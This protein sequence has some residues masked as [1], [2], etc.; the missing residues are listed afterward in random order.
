MNI[1]VQ[2]QPEP[3]QQ[4][5]EQVLTNA[6]LVLPTE[7]L[8]GSVQIKQ[9]VITDVS[10][11]RSTL[12]R[13]L[14]LDGDWLLAGFIEMHTDNIEKQLQPRP[15]VIWPDSR[16]ALLVHDLQIAGAGI[17]TVYDALGL[18]EYSKASARRE[19]LSLSVA[20]ISDPDNRRHCRAEHFLHLRCELADAK[21][22]QFF[23]Q[24]ADNPHVRLMSLM[25]HTPGQR[26]WHDLE[27]YATFHRDKKWSPEDLA[28][29]VRQR[30][31]LQAE[32]SQVNRD[33]L[34]AQ[35]QARGLALASHDDTT[36]EHVQQAHDEGVV[37]SEFPTTVLAAELARSY[38]MATVMG[39]P[40]VVR[41]QSHSGNVSATELARLGLLDILSS[42]Y[43]PA[44]LVQAV[45]KLA[46]DAVL[47]LPEAAN[48]VTMN[49]AARLGLHD[50]GA[51][52]QGLRADL[53]RVTH[54]KQTPVVRQV[55]RQG[56]QVI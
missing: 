54:L 55:W 34:V 2:A 3:L 17:T 21:V 46:N 24:V 15:G 13:A 39:A 51:I 42:D 5:A 16:A 1:A 7:V 49:V 8:Y 37:I 30:Q 14:D 27:K 38:G 29:N 40:N 31:A 43:V 22:D 20:A 12:S 10:P 36:A 47:S 41:G 28:E 50:R 11:G 52:A 44:G 19:L 6:K 35:A 26:Q 48:L 33:Y 25:D 45:F 56:L 53:V 9:G 4:H 18:G 23:D 32:F